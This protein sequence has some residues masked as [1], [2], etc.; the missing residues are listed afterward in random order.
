MFSE[1][2]GWPL[3]VKA[4]RGGYDG[5][6]V[7]S[8][9]DRSE[10]LGLWSELTRAGTPLLVE[11]HVGIDMELSVLVARTPSGEVAAYPVL[12]TRQQ[13]GICREVIAPA[14]I[15]PDLSTEA[16]RLAR[17]IADGLD[18][19]GVLA[20]E[21]FLA[22]GRLLVNELALRPHNSG[23]LTIE[24]C[25][26]SQFE[27][28][29]RGILDW[30]LGETGLLAPACAM[31]NVLGPPGDQRVRAGLRDALAVGGAH[32]HLY[33]KSPRAGRKLGHVTAVGEDHGEALERARRAASALVGS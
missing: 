10:A 17:G 7:W 27:Q 1:E 26:T 5:R 9:H 16:I 2:H 19:A 3:V 11:E 14:D 29:L 25:A 33:G 23:H 30:P 12:E 20:V 18:V 31:V 4:R 8:V 6:G 15:S 22:G 21:M 13:D 28:H 32:V 24:G